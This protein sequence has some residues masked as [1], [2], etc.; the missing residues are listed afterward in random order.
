M[1]KYAF[2][3]CSFLWFVNVAD[4][5]SDSVYFHNSK[6]MY[7]TVS[8]TYIEHYKWKILP[9]AG[10]IYSVP[11]YYEFLHFDIAALLSPKPFYLRDSVWEETGG[12]GRS[13]DTRPTHY[14]KEIFENHKGISASFTFCPTLYLKRIYVGIMVG[15]DFGYMSYTLTGVDVDSSSLDTIYFSR[16]KKHDLYQDASDLPMLCFGL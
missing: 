2:L 6:T 16:K 8:P 5:G 4:A 10:V 3:I 9:Q 11:V 14:D 7:I 12:G 15:F 1:T 13:I